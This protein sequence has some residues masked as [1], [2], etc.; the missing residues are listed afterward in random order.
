MKDSEFLFFSKANPSYINLDL[1]VLHTLKESKAYQL[2]HTARRQCSAVNKLVSFPG[3]DH[4]DPYT[5]SLLDCVW[6]KAVRFGT[7]PRNLRFHKSLEQGL[8]LNR[9]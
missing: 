5:Q 1:S 2:H 8:N 7:S 6:C 9:S 3:R 4:F